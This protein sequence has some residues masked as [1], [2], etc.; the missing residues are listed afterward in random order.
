MMIEVGSLSAATH[1]YIYRLYREN[2]SMTSPGSPIQSINVEALVAMNWMMRYAL[3][4]KWD[5]SSW[6]T[7]Y[8]LVAQLG[9]A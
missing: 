3:V 4:L 6:V 5:P 2:Q 1:H 7:P 9:A 8:G